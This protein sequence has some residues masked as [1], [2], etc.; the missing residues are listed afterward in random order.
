MNLTILKEF[1]ARF[2]HTRS[3][4]RHFRSIALFESLTVGVSRDLPASLSH[5][6][7]TAAMSD[8]NVVLGHL[9]SH[10]ECLSEAK[11]A[12]ILDRVGLNEVVHEKPL[13]WWQ[14]LW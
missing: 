2:V 3:I 8:A 6:L 4:A 1:F 13:P 5:E 14:H 9:D 10:M 12:A 11:A 7:A